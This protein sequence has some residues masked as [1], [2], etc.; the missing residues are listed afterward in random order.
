MKKVDDR[1]K[2]SSSSMHF[3]FFFFFKGCTHGIWKLPGS[4]S[5]EPELQLLAYA[6]A[7]GI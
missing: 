6:T 3:F 4:G 7:H 1:D 5:G 2:T